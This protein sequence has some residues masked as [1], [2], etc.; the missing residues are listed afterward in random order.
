MSPILES[1]ESRSYLSVDLTGAIATVPRSAASGETLAVTIVVKNN[2]RKTASGTLPILFEVSDYHS[3]AN[4]LQV[5]TLTNLI[6]LRNRAMATLNLKVPLALGMP[7]GSFY[8]VAVVDPTNVFN[9]SSL[10]DKTSVSARP[11]RIT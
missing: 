3:G 7:T 11:V 6:R 10:S 5:A 9:E 8:I 2:G 4:P 1:L